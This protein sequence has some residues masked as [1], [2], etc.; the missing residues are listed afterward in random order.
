MRRQRGGHN[1]PMNLNRAATV[2]MLTAVAWSSAAVADAA[3]EIT[4]VF[5]RVV[6]APAPVKADDGKVHLAYELLLV[7]QATSTSTVQRV[8]ALSGNHAIASLDAP[9]LAALQVPFDGRPPGTT[10]PPGGSAM[11]LMDIALPRGAKLP[12]RLVHRLT[13]TQDPPQP[14]SATTY[15]TAPATVV[16]RA[17]ILISPPLRGPRWVVGN[18]CCESLTSHRGAVLA[19]NGGLHAPERFAI[20][21]VQLT[22]QNTL[23]TGPVGTLSSYAFFGDDVLSVAAGKVIAK[24]DGMAEGTPPDLPAGITAANAGGNHLVIDIGHGHYAFYAH[25]QPGSMTVKIGDRVKTG[26]VLAKL[27]NTGNS[28]APH[29]HF[30]I[31]DTPS[32]LGSNGLPFRLTSFTVQGTIADMSGLFDG[33][34]VSYTPPPAGVHRG[35]LPLNQQVIDFPG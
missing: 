10:L 28:D 1:R 7:N 32:P 34:P 18:G 2:L 11:V 31:M 23:F 19:S 9:Q 24:A 8:D 17:A 22:P 29:L 33:Q 35:E 21:F 3:D 30:H 12:Q 13:I 4:P 26:Q 16:Q 5:A 15:L 25:L 20:D 14:K 6:A 27:G